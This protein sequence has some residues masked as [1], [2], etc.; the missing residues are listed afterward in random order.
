MERENVRERSEVAERS[1]DGPLLSPCFFCE[2]S[3]SVKENLYRNK[4]KRETF[5]DHGAK[6]K[7][8]H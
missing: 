4:K 5:D 6:N 8:T 1:K 3:V 7:L 2:S